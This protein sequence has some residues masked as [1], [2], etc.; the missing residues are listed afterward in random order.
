MLGHWFLLGVGCG[1]GSISGRSDVSAGCSN[2]AHPG[3]GYELT[4]V[5]LCSDHSVS[6]DPASSAGDP[7]GQCPRRV[8]GR[9]P[10]TPR[11]GMSR[12]LGRLIQPCASCSACRGDTRGLQRSSS[13]APPPT[14]SRLE[15]V[16][17]NISSR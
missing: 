1:Q 10:D 9:P 3:E 6:G 5:P 14:G 16:R 8:P 13:V 2:S 17:A 15:L 12:P 7:Q 11:R 4:T